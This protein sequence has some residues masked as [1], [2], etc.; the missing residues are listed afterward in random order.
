[1]VKYL[2]F[3]SNLVL[4]LRL[5]LQLGFATKQNKTKQYFLSSFQ[6]CVF[7]AYVCFEHVLQQ[8]QGCW[9]IFIKF[10]ANQKNHQKDLLWVV[11]MVQFQ[12]FF[13]EMEPMM[14]GKYLILGLNCGVVQQNGVDSKVV[15]L[16]CVDVMFVFV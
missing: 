3:D 6:F 9:R 14:E 11:V 10:L 2:R 1:M 4:I 12:N 7:S 16:L 5:N 13:I 8:L 15:Q